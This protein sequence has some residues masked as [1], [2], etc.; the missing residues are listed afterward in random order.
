MKI[1]FRII[2]L[3]VQVAWHPMDVLKSKVVCYVINSTPRVCVTS[4]GFVLRIAE[5]E[6]RT[7]C[8]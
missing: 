6:C 5:E 8:I 7:L 2:V 1:M 3:W 4:S